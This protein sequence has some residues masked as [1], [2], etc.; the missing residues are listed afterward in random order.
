[1]SVGVKTPEGVQ[2]A[3][4][5]RRGLSDSGFVTS[6]TELALPASEKMRRC[7]GRWHIWRR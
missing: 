7:R 3:A 2:T 5:M 4:E 1:M 6:P